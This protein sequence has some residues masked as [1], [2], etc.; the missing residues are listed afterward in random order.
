MHC[1]VPLLFS[2]DVEEFYPAEPGQDPRSTP[3][4]VLIE[5]YLAVLRRVQ[6][7]AT[8]FVVGDVARRYPNLLRAMVADGHELACHGNR[9]VPL[10]QLT[11]DTFR[12]DLCANRAA[13]EA[14]SGTPVR[15]FRAPVLSL[16]KA[17][18]WAYEVLAAEK[19]EYSSSVLPAPN[20]LYGWPEFGP[21]PRRQAGILEV[22]VSLASPV[23]IGAIGSMPLFSGTYFRVMPWSLVQR[24]LRPLPAQRPLVCYFHPYDID[25]EQP[26]TMHAGVG[27]KRLLNALLFARR[28]SLMKRV[29]LLLASARVVTT[30]HDYA[31]SR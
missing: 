4:P 23:G 8:F 1:R 28:R 12:E 15:G 6:A 13:V 5:E 7:R 14:A 22:P 20:P 19:F 24:Q 11:P 21:D 17:T 10:D 16:T 3:L 18:A 29:S 25:H 26:W 31:T 30:Y 2:V 27:G 9:H